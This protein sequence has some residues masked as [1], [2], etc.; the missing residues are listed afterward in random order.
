L[1]KPVYFEVQ[2]AKSDIVAAP[3][4]KVRLEQSG[5]RK[6]ITIDDINK[7]L[8]SA[9]QKRA[10]RIEK[11]LSDVKENLSRIELVNKRR[12]S[13]EKHMEECISTKCA[14]ADEK[15]KVQIEGI[16]DKA[17][18][19]NRKV[20]TKVAKTNEESCANTS[21]K[22]QKTEEKLK[23]AAEKREAHLE[24]ARQTAVHLA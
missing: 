13:E 14:I 10:A 22:K 20:V 19:H 1:N 15:R 18:E 16:A 7:K 23:R 6:S 17:R 5:S 3:A 11:H 21:A 2:L 4:V 9:A 24:K 8:E 12:T